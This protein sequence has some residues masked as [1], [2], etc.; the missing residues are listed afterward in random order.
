VAL[1]ESL[2]LDVL[3]ELTGLGFDQASGDGSSCQFMS[4]GD[5]GGF[6]FVNA[7]VTQGEL[8]LYTT[9]LPEYEEATIAGLPALVTEQQT[10]V[11]L[12]DGRVLDI[13]VA[14]DVSDEQVTV[15]AAEVAAV[16]AERLIP[17]L[18]ER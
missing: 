12:P 3:D 15:S 6:H 5:D 10:I 11:E 16:V 8:E 14:I 7:Y 2:T 13:S 1:C 9:W 4:I 18:L 17:S